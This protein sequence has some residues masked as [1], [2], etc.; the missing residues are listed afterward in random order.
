M[1]TQKDV[2][3]LIIRTVGILTILYGVH[4]VLSALSLTVSMRGSFGGQSSWISMPDTSMRPMVTA[5]IVVGA[6]WVVIGACAIR[7]ASPLV[8]LCYRPLPEPIDV[9]EKQERV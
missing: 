5:Y 6:L 2:F 3:G 4:S 1:M 7:F 8:E 9:E